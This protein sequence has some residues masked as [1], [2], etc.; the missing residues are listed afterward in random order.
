MD[1][2]FF[3]LVRIQLMRLAPT[4][5]FP[6]L[7]LLRESFAESLVDH[8]TFL[9]WLSQLVATSNLAQLGFVALLVDEYLEGITDNRAFLAPLVEGCL[10]KFAE[11]RHN[12][13]R[14]TQGLT[15]RYRTDRF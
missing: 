14:A 5:G 3:I 4:Y 2:S 7:S 11:V 15:A 9:L 1:S 6:S 13:S 8:A 12:P 10:I